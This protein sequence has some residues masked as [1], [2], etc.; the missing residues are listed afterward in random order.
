MGHSRSPAVN[1]I[2]LP[3]C[4]QAHAKGRCEGGVQAG[5]RTQWWPFHVYNHWALAQGAFTVCVPWAGTVW[6]Y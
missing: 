2:C 3:S 6:H 4:P 1:Y 5:K